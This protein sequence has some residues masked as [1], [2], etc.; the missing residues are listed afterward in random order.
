MSIK[1]K[2]IDENG[3]TSYQRGSEKL[4]EKNLEIFSIN[5]FS[6]TVNDNNTFDYR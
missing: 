2:L 1:K 5:L 4:K 3:L 6:F